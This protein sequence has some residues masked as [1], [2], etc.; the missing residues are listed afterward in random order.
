MNPKEARMALA[1]IH[2]KIAEGHNRIATLMEDN[3]SRTMEDWKRDFD[4]ATEFVIK[5]EEKLDMEMRK[6][7]NNNDHIIVIEEDE[8]ASGN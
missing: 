4:I 3:N 8:S 5:W 6:L 1:T 2:R 7:S